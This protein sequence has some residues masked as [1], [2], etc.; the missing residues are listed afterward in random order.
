M[1]LF[2]I[3]KGA[4]EF[5]M[6]EDQIQKVRKEY[7]ENEGSLECSLVTET[8]FDGSEDEYRL[9]VSKPKRSK[10]VSHKS[11]VNPSKGGTGHTG[12]TG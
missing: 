7:F 3:V 12:Q 1:D 10:S 9:S 2:Y 4:V 8:Y 11:R 6:R 5:T